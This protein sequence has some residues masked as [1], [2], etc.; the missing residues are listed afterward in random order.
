MPAA[1][2]PARPARCTAGTPTN[3]DDGNAC[4]VDGCSVTTGCTHNGCAA[5]GIPCNDG[6]ACTTNDHCANASSVAVPL[7]YGDNNPC[8]SDSCNPAT[9]PQYVPVANGTSCDDGNPCTS[10]DSCQSGTC[11]AGPPTNCNDGN[12]CTVDG[13]NINTGCTHNGG[14]ANGDACND[15]NP[16]TRNDHCANANCVGSKISGCP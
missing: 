4:T 7:S 5:N 2:K 6:N 8:T 3:C 12:Q 1:P 9:G 10:T 15:G 14:A 16:C 11:S 13:C